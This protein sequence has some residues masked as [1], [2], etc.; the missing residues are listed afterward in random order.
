MIHE[1][2]DKKGFICT[3]GKP[4]EYPMYVFAHWDET[5]DFTCD[6]CGAKWAILR[7]TAKSNRKT[8]E[9]LLPPKVMK[10]PCEA[11]PYRKDVASGVWAAEEYDKL[12]E[13]DRPTCDQPRAIFSCH[14]APSNI[15]H[16]WAVCHSN[17]GHE[18]ELLALRIHGIK[19]PP[20]AV[21]LFESGEAASRHG[22]KDISK[23]K[24]KAIATMGKLLK[25]HKRLRDAT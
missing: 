11:C 16:G 14:A 20:A 25:K 1:S 24:K 10:S 7:G 9:P 21:P 5:L 23:P 3:C 12:V 18:N 6:R 4:V 19:P 15:C 22:K 8:A 2:K 17:R 13:Y